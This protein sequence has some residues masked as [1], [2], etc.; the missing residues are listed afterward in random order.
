MNKKRHKNNLREI[1][2]NK[3][4]NKKIILL[5][6]TSRYI[7]QY[8]LLLL[9]KLKNSCNE[10][11]VLASVD[12]TSILLKDIAEFREWELSAKKN[13]SLNNFFKS[14]IQLF[15]NVKEISPYI[16]HSHTIKSNL[17]ISIINFFFRINTI[18]SFAGMGRL[19]NS[20]G[21]KK[22][23]FII[24]LKT[25]YFLSIYQ[26]E[27]FFIKKNYNRVKLIFQNPIDIK[28]FMNCI[29]YSD[30]KNLF[31]LIPGSGV[32]E[33]YFQSK[34]KF[35]L[36]KNNNLDFIYCAR[37]E[38][39]KGIK[40]F[41]NLSFYYPN[42]KFFIYGDLESNSDDYL[43]KEEISYF[44]S[45]NKNLLFM[46]YVKDPL[47]KHHNDKTIVM[48]PSNYGEGLPRAIIEA[49]SLE[50][51]VIASKKSCVGL[52]N[53]KNLFIVKDNNL[54]SY[55][56]EI[57]KIILKKNNNNLNGFLKKSKELVFKKYSE[58]IIVAKTL[59]IYQ[60]FQNN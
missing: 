41:I 42:S 23:L 21:V 16:V 45:K 60:Q 49:F 10:L 12:R 51:P 30:V 15:F 47:L 11:F 18:I 28:F 7:F 3:I 55:L 56:N 17:L 57:Q 9:K 38:N 48:V 19:S 1:P 14:F 25:I 24:I 6:N 27:K 33:I 29:G 13:Y 20:K 44:K 26:L 8:R 34:K 59:K 32:P 37:L 53:E 5:S 35:F 58:S 46:N 52:F 54:I 4:K 43:R 36:E 50:L 40:T 22:I 31:N 39:S 2:L